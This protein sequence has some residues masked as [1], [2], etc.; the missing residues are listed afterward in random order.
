MKDS[1]VPYTIATLPKQ[2]QC[3]LPPGAAVR[4]P[5]SS[6]YNRFPCVCIKLCC[7]S[8]LYPVKAVSAF[9]HVSG[10]IV[11]TKKKVNYEMI[12]TIFVV[13]VGDNKQ[14]NQKIS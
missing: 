1:F 3:I 7:R 2:P 11:F 10:K 4:G 13:V 8:N 6:S 9:V 14:F 5:K 12:M